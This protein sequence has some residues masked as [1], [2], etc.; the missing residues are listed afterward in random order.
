LSEAKAVIKISADATELKAG[1]ASAVGELDKIR[2]EGEKPIKSGGKYAE[3]SRHLKEIRT[4]AKDAQGGIQALAA[5]QGMKALGDMASKVSATFGTMAKEI[6]E[7]GGHVDDMRRKLAATFDGAEVEPL[8][9]KIRELGITPPFNDEAFLGAA[10]TLQK[11][12][13][14]VESNLERVGNIA[15]KTGQD[16]TTVAETFG[17]VSKGGP[18][19]SRAVRTM[20]KQFGISGADLKEF[21]AIVDEAGKVLTETPAQA[22]AAREALERIAD[23][24]FAGAMDAMASPIDELQGRMQILREEL[25][26][27][28]RDVQ[29]SAAAAMI[30]LVQGFTEGLTPGATEFVGVG[31]GVV[32]VL[33]DIAGGAIG[34]AAQIGQVA[35]GMVSAAPAIT[36]MTTAVKGIAAANSA[37]LLS[38]GPL[39]LAGGAVIAMALAYA[40]A[41]SKA[42]KAADDL[43]NAD[44]KFQASGTA[45]SAGQIISTSAEELHKMGV[46]AQGARIKMIEIRRAMEGVTDPKV[47]EKLKAQ[48][49]ALREKSA[50]LAVLE[51][52][53]KKA[54][55]AASKPASEAAPDDKAERDRS[56]AEQKAESDKRR[57]EEKTERERVAAE[58]KAQRERDAA[59]RKKEAEEKSAERKREAEAI[60]AEREKKAAEDKAQR[61]RERVE[62]KKALDEQR[63]DREEARQ[64]E[65]QAAKADLQE[66]VRDV[67]DAARAK[68]QSAIDAEVAVRKGFDSSRPG[69]KES[70]MMSI[71]EAF[72]Y[73]MQ[74]PDGV[75]RNNNSAML[76]S[77]NRARTVEEGG[78][79]LGASLSAAATAAD[80][81]AAPL[82]TLGAAAGT[83]AGG[84]GALTS[85]AASAAAALSSVR[86]GGGG[87]AGGGG[88]DGDDLPPAPEG[89]TTD[90]RYSYAPGYGPKDAK[91]V[92]DG[93]SGLD[94]EGYPVAQL[95]S[96]REMSAPQRPGAQPG[97]S[98]SVRSDV[99]Q[100]VVVNGAANTEPQAQ[101]VAREAAKLVEQQQQRKRLMAGPWR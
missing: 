101:A 84:F 40:D 16:I 43:A 56:A 65:R 34:T 92:A 3:L 59:E 55:E 77:Q 38:M 31:V 99:R 37:A 36:K 63:R 100:T 96:L 57:A 67:E 26:G 41:V 91:P 82:D 52:R 11:F 20:A 95:P 14:D 80:A 10:R 66:Q 23:S 30:P 47:I 90:G 12:G 17:F 4:N 75:A 32:G 93:G 39:V 87:G 71:E 15:A 54:A 69:G 45:T 19:A 81:L 94:S 72:S 25:G 64:A 76:G 28:W 68:A 50:A 18:E 24:N 86:G 51:D 97:G 27:P 89:W 70:P 74:S 88:G 61:E 48:V 22:D 98:T 13:V 49:T 46:T 1:V 6:A 7:A 2:Q 33:G 9:A 29:E 62:A 60:K 8:L 83:V 85:A 53:E 58:Q 21:G 42:A 35:T 79:S 73:G 5:S 44:A 78:K